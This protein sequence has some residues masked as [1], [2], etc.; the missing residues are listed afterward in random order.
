M[1]GIPIAST[2]LRW[3]AGMTIL[4]QVGLLVAV[5]IPSP[6]ASRRMWSR[7]R[8]DRMSAADTVASD[9]IGVWFLPVFAVAGLLAV[10][11][12]VILPGSAEAFLV[13]AQS[14]FPGWLAPAGG[15]CLLA[16][17]GVIAA[18]VFTLKRRTVF[19]AGGQ[20]R[21]LL[22]DGIFGHMRH[23][24]VG[25]MGAIYLG[26]FLVFPSPL[27]LAA[28]GCFGWHQLRRMRQE[29]VLLEQHFGQAYWDYRRR[30]GRFWPKRFAGTRGA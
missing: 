30:V 27:V 9:P 18:A 24:I 28:L 5:P 13:P 17:N 11:A 8:E 19:D 23:P 4:F 15:L 6:V 16:G 14:R 22:T 12:A 25:G 7:R 2:A 1:D 21:R 29:E 10:I 26:F 20:S 3:L